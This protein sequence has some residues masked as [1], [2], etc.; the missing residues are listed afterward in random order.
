MHIN[1]SLYVSLILEIIYLYSTQK[2][3]DSLQKIY[4]NLAKTHKN[5]NFIRIK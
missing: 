5:K 2:P 4:P 3:H 1:D